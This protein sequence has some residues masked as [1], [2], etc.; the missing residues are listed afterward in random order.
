MAELKFFDSLR[1]QCFSESLISNFCGS[2]VNCVDYVT[3][4]WL[5]VYEDKIEN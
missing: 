5:I 3:E 1:S 2:S 4:C